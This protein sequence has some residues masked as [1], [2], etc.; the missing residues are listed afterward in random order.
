MGLLSHFFKHK[1][2]FTP[3]E[4]AAIQEAVRIAEQR[5]SGEVRVFV[6]SRCHFV[7]PV[8][9]AVEVFTSLKMDQTIERNGV[10][11]YIAMHDRQL[12]IYGDEG[13]H[14]KVGID[15]WN[16][17][18]SKMI[19]FFKGKQFG[20][21]IATIVKEIGETLTAHFPFDGTKDKNELSD[22]IVF[23]K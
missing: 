16:A 20:E 18:V 10:L 11:V 3:Q 22:E 23:G 19:S 17:E 1:D 14:Q 13:I 5:T 9:R 4:Q 15:F 6:E 2:W 21:G 8:D 7:D 12:A